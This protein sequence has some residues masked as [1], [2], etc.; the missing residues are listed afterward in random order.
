MA[1]SA[2]DIPSLQFP[3]DEIIEIIPASYNNSAKRIHIDGLPQKLV[4]SSP[5]DIK[6]PVP[7]SGAVTP[8]SG[9]GTPAVGS[10]T[11]NAGTGTQTPVSSTEGGVLPVK[12]GNIDPKA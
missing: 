6:I 3:R 8:F 7:P 11:P 1:C 10:G 5:E 4:P 12:R 2:T 9:L